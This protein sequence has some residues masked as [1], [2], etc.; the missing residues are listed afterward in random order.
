MRAEIDHSARRF[1]SGSR[2]AKGKQLSDGYL[3]TEQDHCT[4]CIDGDGSR[5]FPVCLV[6]VSSRH[7]DHRG[8]Q[9][10]ALTAPLSVVIATAWGRNSAHIAKLP[11]LSSKF[12]V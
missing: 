7:N 5:F 10:N 8:F 9:N 6:V 1:L 2:I 4:V 12:V 3:Q 11:L